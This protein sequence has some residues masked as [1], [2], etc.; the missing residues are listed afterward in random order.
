MLGLNS[1]EL[2]LY[3]GAGVMAAAVLLFLIALIVHRISGRKLR[4]KLE[5]EYGR[6]S[7]D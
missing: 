1:S 6:K 5:R 7:T 2:I 3:A 4:R